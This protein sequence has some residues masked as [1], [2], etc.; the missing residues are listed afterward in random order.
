MTGALVWQ[1]QCMESFCWHLFFI[2][3]VTDEMKL[4]KPISCLCE[5]GD[6]AIASFHLVLL[7]EDTVIHIVCEG[8][9]IA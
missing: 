5:L 7:H 6:L 2:W 1:K 3:P 4:F 8:K 9:L